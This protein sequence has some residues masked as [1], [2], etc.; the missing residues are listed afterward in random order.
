MLNNY[1][2][3]RDD[4]NDNNRG[5]ESITSLTMFEMDKAKWKIIWVVLIILF[6]IFFRVFFYLFA[7]FILHMHVYNHDGQTPNC[8]TNDGTIPKV[9]HQVMFNTS[10]PKPYLDAREN[11]N[12]INSNFVSILWNKTMVDNLVHTHYPFLKELFYGYDIWVKRADVARYLTIHHYGGIYT[13]LDSN[14]TGRLVVSENEYIS[15]IR[16]NNVTMY[17]RKFVVEND[18]NNCTLFKMFL[19]TSVISIRFPLF[20]NLTYM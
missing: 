10:I 3:D 4:K 6:L 2:N 15:I 19:I 12:R 9:I 17:T 14:C 13:D 18:P 8:P 16:H 20:Y 11:C 5:K 7:E 1:N